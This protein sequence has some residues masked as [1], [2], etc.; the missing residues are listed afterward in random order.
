MHEQRGAEHVQRDKDADQR[1]RCAGHQ[2]D[3][4]QQFDR[5]GEHRGGGSSRNPHPDEARDG[6]VH[7]LD[8]ELLPAV[9]D[10]DDTKD[11]PS[12]E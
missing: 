7:T 10:E 3:A 4:A 2:Q 12:Q 1:G 8:D 6:G 5:G 9:G 11:Q